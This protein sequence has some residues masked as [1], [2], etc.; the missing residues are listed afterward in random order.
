VSHSSNS[1]AELGAQEL[2]GP[3]RQVRVGLKRAEERQAPLAAPLKVH[4]AADQLQC[5][6]QFGLRELV[7]Q[8]VQLLAHCAHAR[9]LCRPGCAGSDTRHATPIPLPARW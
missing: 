9:I 7:H 8:M 4:A 1:A 6:S 3:L 5:R 2:L